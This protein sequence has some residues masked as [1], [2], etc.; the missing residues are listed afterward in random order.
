MNEYY[1]RPNQMQEQADALW[2]NYLALRS[3]SME[4]Q[5]VIRQLQWMSGFETQIE[6]LKR[7]R[8]KM[9]SQYAALSRV[10]HTLDEAAQYYQKCETGVL[11]GKT[12]AK[13]IRNIRRSWQRADTT[14]VPWWG[15]AAKPVGLQ[16]ML[17]TSIISRFIR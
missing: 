3:C 5:A 6:Q 12:S 11:N 7:L 9:D 14:S 10:S 8:H 1:A 16:Q 15:S 13:G 4:T 17:P 2:K